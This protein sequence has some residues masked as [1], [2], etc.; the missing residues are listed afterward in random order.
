MSYT[1]LQLYNDALLYC[2][3]TALASLSEDREAR[4]LLDQ[5][6]DTG[7]IEDCLEEAPWIFALRTVKGDYDPTI[8]PSFG[9]RRV[10]AK[11]TDWVATAE[12]CEDEYFNSPLLRY[13]DEGG[14]FHSDL[15]IIYIRYVSNDTSYGL[16]LDAWPPS[17]NCFVA[18]HFASKIILKT[19]S[20]EKKQKT[21]YAIRENELK[22]AKNKNAMASPTKFSPPG[23]WQMS[24]NGTRRRRDRGNRNS[25]YG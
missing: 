11:P 9:Y 3:E 23:K 17:F 6:Y 18:A 13:S 2:G 16:D 22:G 5:V 25:F 12:L 1:K 21:I 14:Y 19:T 20:D 4:Y 8:T 10:F 7:G 15:D 24:R